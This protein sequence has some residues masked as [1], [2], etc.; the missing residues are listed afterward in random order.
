MT[1][2]I[3]EENERIKRRYLTFLREAKRADHATVGK[4]ADAILRFERSTGF[5][6]FKRFHIDQA[7]NFKRQLEADVNSRTGKPL[8]KA[9]ID[10]T[11]RLVK[12][13][14]QWLACQPGYKSRISYADAEYF[15]LN[16]KDSRIAHTDR[17]TPYPTI[18]QCRHAF[19]LM[20]NG[21]QIE[22]RDRAIFAFLMLTGA[23]DGAIASAR[24]KRI[25]L[26]D[27]CFYQDARDVKT[28]F[29]KTF[30]T[31]FLPVDAAYLDCLTEWITYL[32]Q[33]RLFGY[34]DA[35]FPKPEQGL[36]DG[37]FATIGLMREPYSN[38]SKVREVIKGAFINAG[39]PP[40]APHSFRKT[41]VKYGDQICNTREQF[42]AWSQNLGHDSVVTTISAY[43]PVSNER[44]AELIR[45]M[46]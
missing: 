13:F 16:R 39:L 29:A 22:K 37:C 28:K 21:T 15:N 9:T 10:G 7:T 4:A 3:H 12:A 11:L 42:K 24:L 19:A 27:A 18:E 35:L 23:R 8:S 32:R 14:V 36:V 26:V 6:P 44:Q 38:A 41:L 17:D 31:W 40:F 2:K 25:N 43:C 34:E 33:V 1:R 30:T 20:P 45:N 5:K 46:G